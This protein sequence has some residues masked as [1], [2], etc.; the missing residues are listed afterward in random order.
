MRSTI[1]TL[2][3]LLLLSVIAMS[4]AQD[5]TRTFLPVHQADNLA[6][7]SLLADEAG[8][9]HMTLP[10][11]TG[12]GFHYA[13]CPPGCSGPDDIAELFFS[14]DSNG[15]HAA[16]ALD[17]QG[18]PHILVAGSMELSYAW[19]HGDCT[20][21]SGWSSGLLESYSQPELDVTGHALA[22]GPD[23]RAHFIQHA[24]RGIL[25]EEHRTWYSTCQ[26]DC[27][28]A[29]NWQSYLIEDEQSYLYPS[30]K[31]RDDGA[32]VM[33]MI[34]SANPDL[35]LTQPIA[36]YMECTGNCADGDSWVGVGLFD[37]HDMTW[38]Q[39]VPPAI[40]LQ[41]TGA[42]KPRM[43]YRAILEDGTAVL[44]WN[45]CD[46][47][48]CTDGDS[49]HTE[50]IIDST[51]RDF[52][53]GLH[54]VLDETDRPHI[55]YT[56]GGSIIQVYC[57]DHCDNQDSIWDLSL[58]EAGNDI[59]ADDIFLYTNCV[60]GAWFLRDPGIALL[61][62][63]RMAALYTAEDYSF[64]GTSSDPSKPSCPIGVDMSL[65]RLSL[66]TF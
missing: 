16:L 2:W 53:S 44:I 52:G 45:V 57:T 5:V 61:P 24:S 59:E 19:C 4:A 6:R 20:S 42:G 62:D 63:G 54:M 14:T 34:A 27:H 38:S 36:A 65:G 8:G 30:L 9:L 37:A 1:N 39:D 35:G 13:Y 33:G 32:L 15:P 7:T 31:V 29:G 48:D 10:S 22:I 51:E 11:I 28:L 17:P 3:A 60:V 49:W 50:G 18:R 12:S 40:T 23:G 43:T 55:A 25:F 21:E 64:G 58:I 47:A 66:G 46:A 26:A 41:L 56:V